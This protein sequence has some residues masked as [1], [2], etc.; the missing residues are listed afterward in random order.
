MIARVAVQGALWKDKRRKK[1]K[2]GADRTDGVS[3]RYECTYKLQAFRLH[4][5]YHRSE[6]NKAG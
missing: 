6:A 1:E 5:N 3:V 4:I 2:A